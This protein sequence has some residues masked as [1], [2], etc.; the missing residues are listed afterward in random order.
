M[1]TYLQHKHPAIQLFFILGTA[2]LLSQV[3]TIVAS[4]VTNLLLGVDK[5]TAF[6]ILGGYTKHPEARLIIIVFQIMQFLFLFLATTLIIGYYTSEQPLQYLGLNTLAPATYF[7]KALL[8]VLLSLVAMGMFGLINSY[9]PLPKSMLATEALQNEAIK[10]IA[11]SN[12]IYQLI[13]SIIVVGL[14]AA[15]GEELF[16]RAMLQPIFIKW[17]GKSWLGILIIAIIFSAI[18]MQFSGFLPRLALG[19]VL[20][21]LYYYSRSIWVTIF[22]HFLFNTIQLVIVFNKP[23][24]LTKTSP[25]SGQNFII[26]LL[27]C[28]STAAILYL[29]SRMAT[30][31]SANN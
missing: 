25:I 21:Y 15:I 29:F 8:L 10:N 6:N 11:L 7:T 3:G 17:T 28:L 26:I 30:Y 20:G 9:I 18:H 5:F 19:L 14:F 2:F 27:G 12:T 23:E 31:K 22:F 4:V 1:N 16:F 13:A 24:Q